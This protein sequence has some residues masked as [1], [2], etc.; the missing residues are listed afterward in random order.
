MNELEIG[1]VLSL[2]IRYNNEGLTATKKHPYLIVGVDKELNTVEVAQLDSLRG[3][4]YKAMRKSNKII[5]SDDPDETV[6]DQ[7]SYIQLDNTFRI[8]NSQHLLNYR[9]QESKLSDDKLSDV[10]DSYKKYHEDN[11]IEDNKNVYMTINEIA[12]LNKL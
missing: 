1:Q 3:K 7:D 10:L 8:E 2:K 11:D 4:E 5:Y 9:R 6:I 12:E